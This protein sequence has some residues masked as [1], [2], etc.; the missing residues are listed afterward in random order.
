MFQFRG[1]NYITPIPKRELPIVSRNK[2]P[3]FVYLFWS[4]HLWLLPAPTFM[5]HILVAVSHLLKCVSLLNFVVRYS[6][7]QMQ[8]LW[9][10]NYLD[11]VVHVTYQSNN[12][13]LNNSGIVSSWREVL[14]SGNHIFE[15]FI[16]WFCNMN[17]SGL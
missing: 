14:S 12:K 11:T 5:I 9:F 7:N 10:C 4:Y 13:I 2:T 1:I 8:H 15:R 3:L 6:E 16:T 17:L